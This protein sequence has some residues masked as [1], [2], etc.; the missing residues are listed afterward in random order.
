MAKKYNRE[1]LIEKM[2]DY[3]EKFGYPKTREF[4]KNKNYPNL[5]TY[6]KEFGSFQN[7]LSIIGIELTENQKSCAIEKNIQRKSC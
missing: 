5:Y 2:K 3:Y 7:A 6:R 4:N 1:E